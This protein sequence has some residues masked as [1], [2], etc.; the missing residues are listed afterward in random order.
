M[1]SAISEMERRRK[2]QLSY[3]RKYKITPRTIQKP[4][5]NIVPQSRVRSNQKRLKVAEQAEEYAVLRENIPREIEKFRQ[6]MFECAE[7]MDFEEAAIYRDKMLH[8]QKMQ[9]ELG[10]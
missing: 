8:L 4:I 6:L 2:K 5:P 3:N 9:I 7:R 1:K 10:L